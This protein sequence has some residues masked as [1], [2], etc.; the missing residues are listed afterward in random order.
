M[1]QQ[2][3][4]LL[5]Y[6]M[7]LLRVWCIKMIPSPPS[8]VRSSSTTPEADLNLVLKPEAL[9]RSS[10]IFHFMNDIRNGGSSSGAGDFNLT[11]TAATVIGPPPG[12]GNGNHV[13]DAGSTVELLG[14]ALTA[15]GAIR[16]KLIS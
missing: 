14:M 8:M 16:Q 13:P 11:L 6:R 7:Q 12:G 2:A 4:R 10:Y 9:G 15:L 1:A 3:R 5:R